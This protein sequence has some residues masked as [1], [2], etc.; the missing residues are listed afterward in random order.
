[1]PNCMIKIEYSGSM[2][3]SSDSFV[4]NTPVFPNNTQ[5]LTINITAKHYGILDVRIA[6]VK[7]VDILKLF[8]R[9]I[10]SN[11]NDTLLRECSI[12][13]SPDYTELEND[14]MDYSDMGLESQ[15]YSK[16][17]KG[18][19]PSE[20]FDIREY[21]DGDKINRIHWK[22]TAKQRSTMVK[23]YSL[24]MS[25]SVLI[26]V[27]LFI[28]SSESEADPYTGYDSLLE[29]VY[30][31][32]MRLV[33]GEC[34]HSVM[35]YDSTLHDN[36]ELTVTD[37]ESCSFMIHKLL[38]TALPDKQSDSLTA[39]DECVDGYSKVGHFIYCAAYENDNMIS[40]VKDNESA[41]RR[42]LLIMSDTAKADIASEDDGFTVVHVA[43]GY[44]AESIENI[45]L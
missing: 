1:M 5:Y 26:F 6:E 11:K 28:D 25:N 37:F 20:I 33:D 21:N 9:K 29:T 19:D 38:K 36:V 43:E 17:K 12:I 32:S 8:K 7:I 18:D 34:M 40:Y 16:T 15:S 10:V 3:G 14:I 41:F 13:V 22:L 2:G 24:P 30:A 35:W 23:D 4:V 42:T 44:T 31:L 45:C 39:A 27:D